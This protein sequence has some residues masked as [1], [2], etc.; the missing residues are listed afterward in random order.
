MP[1]VITNGVDALST[2]WMTLTLAHWLQLRSG[3]TMRRL[4]N[5]FAVS[6]RLSQKWC[7]PIDRDALL[8][9]TFAK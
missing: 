3:T 8:K 1:A 2:T 6:I 5:W 9:R 4:A 7:E